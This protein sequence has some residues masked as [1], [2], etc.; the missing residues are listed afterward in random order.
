[1]QGFSL[2]LIWYYAEE[3][4]RR[5][6][7]F[8]GGK[9]MDE[10]CDN[11]WI[12]CDNPLLN[13]WDR[14]TNHQM[15]FIEM[16]LSTLQQS[17]SELD[18]NWVLGIQV[19]TWTSSSKQDF[20]L[21]LLHLQCLAFPLVAVTFLHRWEGQKWYFYISDLVVV[22]AVDLLSNLYSCRSKFSEKANQVLTRNLWLNY[23]I[24]FN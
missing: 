22:F 2:C 14:L 21:K 6:K 19:S 10:C 7:E 9:K 12:L 1:M 17:R 11:G 13:S 16:I 5:I 18:M 3:Y 8:W 4:I 23:N 24:I 20:S 15:I